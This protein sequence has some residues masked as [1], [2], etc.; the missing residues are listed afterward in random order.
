MPRDANGNYTAPAG[1]PVT[2]N[3]LIESSWANTLVQDLS[4]EMTDSLSR[5]GKG[6]VTGPFQI[7]DESG[8]VPGLAYSNEPTTGLRRNATGDVR[9]QVLGSDRM[10]WRSGVTQVPE[11]QVSAVWKAVVLEEAGQKVMRGDPGNTIIFSGNDTAAPGWTLFEP[12][13]NVREIIVGPSGAGQGGTFG[14]TID[15]INLTDTAAVTLSGSTSIENTDHTHTYSGT[16]SI[17]S[18]DEQ[19]PNGAGGEVASDPHTHSFSGTTSFVSAAS[20]HGHGVGTLTGTANVSITPRYF[21][22]ILMQLDA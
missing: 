17:N 1:N 3:T 10:R 7:I 14:G 21:R 16:T 8:G 15:P 22:G 20:S 13:A 18:A 4:T 9:M 11:V 12:D 5:T 6:G 19:K 2:S